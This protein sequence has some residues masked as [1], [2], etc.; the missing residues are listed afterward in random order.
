M[1]KKQP[2]GDRRMGTAHRERRRN[3]RAVPTLH[4]LFLEVAR[5]HND[6]TL[7]INVFLQSVVHLFG[8][9]R[10]D[11]TFHFLVVLHGSIDIRR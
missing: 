7:G 11:L 4:L 8:G 2:D 3:W 6:Q 1:V 9:Q 10:L 5:R